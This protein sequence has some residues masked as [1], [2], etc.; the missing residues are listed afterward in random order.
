MG[1]SDKEQWLSHFVWQMLFIILAAF[2]ISGILLGGHVLKYSSFGFTFLF[3]LVFGTMTMVFGFTF[4]T[5]FSSSN[6]AAANTT[7]VYFVAYIPYFFL[8][9]P[10]NYGKLSKGA[11]TAL[12]L[13]PQ[14][15]MAIG[16]RL[17]TATEAGGVGTTV[18]N[19]NQLSTGAD[20]YMYAYICKCILVCLSLSE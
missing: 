15:C 2:I 1:I 14:T 16:T 5:F 11:K 8:T 18:S 6:V 9:N 13:L 3:F 20:A 4:S 17:W 7:L 19:M 10:T 12:C